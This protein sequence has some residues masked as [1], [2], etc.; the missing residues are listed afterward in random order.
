[1]H[2]LSLHMHIELTCMNTLCIQCMSAPNTIMGA[3]MMYITKMIFLKLE[4][5]DRSE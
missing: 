2:I 4:Q 3:I 5:Q 1:M